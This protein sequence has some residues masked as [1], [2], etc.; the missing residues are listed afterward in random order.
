MVEDIGIAMPPI[1]LIWQDRLREL[2]FGSLY[3]TDPD[4]GRLRGRGSLEEALANTGKWPNP[5]LAFGAVMAN[6]TVHWFYTLIGS[7]S[8]LLLSFRLWFRSESEAN[9]S[10]NRVSA[11]HHDLELYLGDE[12]RYHRAAD[13]YPLEGFDR[14]DVTIV[15]NETGLRQDLKGSGPRPT[16]WDH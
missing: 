11:A 1:P 9:D 4:L 16:G 6:G 8:L 5:G 13:P 14:R 2:S 10:R 3:A 7:R 15:T 12:V